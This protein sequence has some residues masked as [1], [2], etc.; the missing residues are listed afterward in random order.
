M[1]TLEKEDLL[2]PDN[3]QYVVK[4]PRKFD[5]KRV[6]WEDINEVIAAKIAKLLGFIYHRSRNCK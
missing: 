3:V 2:S 6:N 5:G 1:S 4:Y